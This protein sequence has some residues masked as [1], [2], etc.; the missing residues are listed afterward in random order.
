MRLPAP[1]SRTRV[2]KVLSGPYFRS[3]KADENNFN[4]LDTRWYDGEFT[5]ASSFAPSAAPSLVPVRHVTAGAP[6]T[7]L[8]NGAAAHLFPTLTLAAEARA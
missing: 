3:A 7:V 5:Y 2:A 4:V 6:R 1:S 8:A